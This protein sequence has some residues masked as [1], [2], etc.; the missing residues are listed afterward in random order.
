MTQSPLDDHSSVQIDDVI[1]LPDDPQAKAVWDALVSDT[2]SRVVLFDR[3]GQILYANQRANLQHG[4]ALG[5]ESI[6]GLRLPEVAPEDYSAERMGFIH[7]VADTGRAIQVDGVADGVSI[8][9]MYRPFPYGPD[10]E[11]GVLAIC[12]DVADMAAADWSEASD[13][14][15]V[16]AR[17]RDMGALSCLTPTEL[18]VLALMG[19]GGTAAQM[20]SRL[21]RS[22]KTVEWHRTMIARKLGVRD[23]VEL[24]RL[25]IRAGLRPDSPPLDEPKGRRRA[26]KTTTKDE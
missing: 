19:E 21:R 20:A 8:R 10:R 9:T 13:V 11:V 22:V 26:K 14:V 2:S 3:D 6:V 23:R 16:E 7:Q 5:R 24:A 17:V 15:H 18:E 25:A 4:S 12:R 1:S